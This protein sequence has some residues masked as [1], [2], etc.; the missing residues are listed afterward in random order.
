MPS[1]E[2]SQKIT[3]KDYRGLMAKDELYMHGM[4]SK[5][6]KQCQEGQLLF[7][8]TYKYDEGTSTYATGAKKRTPAWTDRVLFSQYLPCM[9]LVKYSRAEINVSDHRPVF[10]HFRVKINKVN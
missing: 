5:V 1:K 10:A 4:R 9:T 2:I 6:L 7:D 8:P 3:G